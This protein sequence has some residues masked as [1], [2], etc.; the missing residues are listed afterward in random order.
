MSTKLMILLYFLVF[1]TPAVPTGNG[2]GD[3]KHEGDA[4]QSI[5]KV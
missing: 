2:S 5:K 3:S 1:S 4:I